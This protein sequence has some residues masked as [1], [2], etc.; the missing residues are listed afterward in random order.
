LGRWECP[1]KRLFLSVFF[2]SALFIE[3]HLQ[4]AGRSKPDI[5]APALNEL[6]TA[7]G[8]KQDIPFAINSSG[9]TFVPRLKVAA[10]YSIQSTIGIGDLYGVDGFILEGNLLPDFCSCSEFG[11]EL[12]SLANDLSTP[13]GQL[14]T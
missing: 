10:Y 14:H 12:A 3:C 5:S 8:K 9:L 1:E 6:S 11:T 4:L 2:E 13:L 7:R